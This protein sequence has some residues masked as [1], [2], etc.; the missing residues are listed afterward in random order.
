[1]FNR[2]PVSAVMMLALAAPAV[3]QSEG[4]LK[5]Y[6]EGKRVTLRMDMPGTSDGVDV[7]AGPGG[8]DPLLPLGQCPG[9]GVLGL[10]EGVGA[11]RDGL[12]HLLDVVAHH[13]GGHHP[14]TE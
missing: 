5:S 2:V 14:G 6:F 8:H 4:A 11:H 13:A 10:G 9:P 7:H 3:A 12:V 1:M